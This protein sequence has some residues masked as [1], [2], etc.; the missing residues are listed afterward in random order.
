MKVSV[1]IPVYGDESLSHKCS[2][3]V[4]EQV[5]NGEVVQYLHNNNEVNIGFT[6][7]VNL[8][9]KVA[10]LEHKSDYSIILNQDCFLHENAIQNAIDFM[11][12]HP[13]CFIAG[14]KQVASDLDRITHGGTLECFPN[15]V[16]ET[17]LLSSGDCNKNKMVPWVN[18]A[19][20][21]VRNSEVINVGLMDERFFLICS[22][23]D[24]SYT[25]RSKGYECW[26]IA[27]VS[28]THDQGVT[29]GDRKFENIM[30]MDSVYFH[31][32][33]ITGGLFEDLSGELF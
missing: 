19:C 24:W 4:S 21:I 29:K 28:A 32:K 30:R 11:E 1:L 22:D 15:G 17:G 31:D 26:Y 2:K 10:V 12:K 3:I 23:S 18:G 27:N 14:I 9:M 16:H 33:W 6:K 13:K 20:M 7:A 25:A 8:M 5:F